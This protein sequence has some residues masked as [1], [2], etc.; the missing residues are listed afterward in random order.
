M[1]QL[2]HDVGWYGW[3]GAVGCPVNET[4]V[5]PLNAVFVKWPTGGVVVPSKNASNMKYQLWISADWSSMEHISLQPTWEKEVSIAM[6]NALP[7]IQ[8]SFQYDDYGFPPNFT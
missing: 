7:W 5:L 3:G 2:Y 1:L 8:S 6:N 4:G